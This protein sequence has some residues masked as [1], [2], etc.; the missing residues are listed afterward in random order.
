LKTAA[1]GFGEYDKDGLFA[2][3]QVLSY[4]L[5][6]QRAWLYGMSLLLFVLI[7]LYM[8]LKRR[9]VRPF[10]FAAFATALLPFANLASLVALALILPFMALLY[11]IGPLSA[12]PTALLRAYPV[13]QWMIYVLMS[14]ALVAP[15]LLVQQSS[16][17]GAIKSLRWLPG[18]NL[19]GGPEGVQEAWWW[20]WL[21]NLG[22][23]VLL[24]PCGLLLR[25]ALPER[26]RRM[27]WA[28][29]PTF[30]I[31]NLVVFQPLPGDNAKQ[32]VV[33]YVGGAIAAAAAVHYMWR[34]ARHP[35]FRVLLS[36][37]L[38]TVILSGLLIHVRLQTP[39][40]RWQ[41]ASAEEEELGVAVRDRTA[42]DALFATG[43]YVSHPVLMVGGR[44]L[45]LGWGGQLWTQG[46][47][48]RQHGADLR[49]ILQFGPDAE[50]LIE[51]Y[52]VDYVAISQ[53]E[54]DDYQANPSAYA[55]RYPVAL[56]G[57][58]YTIF[59][60]SPDAISLALANGATLPP[61]GA[62][63]PPSLAS[64]SLATPSVGE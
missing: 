27:V 53:R 17:A 57:A 63:A 60:V 29:M 59:A 18:W 64:P 21:K 10:I 7:L 13:K 35:A 40:N 45:M 32:L 31:A 48:T 14:A 19:A 62:S 54:I 56:T 26:P 6:A 42:P 52:G 1:W 9:D 34:Q 38:V 22:F 43:E 37:V 8:G 20:Y 55:A 24:I 15:Q 33:W 51:Q 36:L 50:P 39:E 23:L 3:N 41:I 44:P 47:D 2:W 4:P 46:Y 11:P 28:M 12:K 58:G 16:S 49:T 25:R 61:E 5:L 30:V